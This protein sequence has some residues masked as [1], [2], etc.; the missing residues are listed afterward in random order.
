MTRR[1]RFRAALGS[2]EAFCAEPIENDRDVAGIL[3]GFAFTFELAWK[4]IQDE[5]ERRGYTEK[6]PRLSF[7]AGF[8]A[9]V[10]PAEDA[11]TWS[12]ALEDRNMV[13]HTYRPDGARDLAERIGDQ[14]LPAF[15]R[16]VTRLD[17]AAAEPV[18]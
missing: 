9:G 2:L 14:Y 13:A 6:G 4:V 10:V 12:D 1:E 5:T 17:E 11:D 8:R 3:Q 18:P 15:E 7:A 16:L